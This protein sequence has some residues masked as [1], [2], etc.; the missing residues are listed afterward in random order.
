MPDPDHGLSGASN[1][2][3]HWNIR[4]K[5][6]ILLVVFGL[7][8]A[9]AVLSVL[10]IQSA[11]VKDGLM[12]KLGGAAVT[13]A[14]VV[15]L[16]LSERYGDA[17]AFAMNRAA[18]DAVNWGSPDA[19]NEL[20]LAMNGYVQLY[21]VYALTMIVAPDG[22]VLAVNSIDARCR[23]IDTRRLYAANFLGAPWIARPMKGEFLDGRNGLTGTYVHGPYREAAVVD[24]AGRDGL[25]LAFAA[26]IHDSSGTFLGVWIN[27]IDFAAIEELIAHT[28]RAIS[29]QG[30]DAA[31]I[32]LLDR[33][34]RVL[35]ERGGLADGVLARDRNLV[36][37]ELPPAIRSREANHGAIAY[38]A[39]KTGEPIA[40]G[41]AR[42]V[43][44]LDFP[45]LGWTVIVR[46]PAAEVFAIW[47]HVFNGL[48]LTLLA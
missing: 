37:E 41:F 12:V 22:R 6:V 27:L 17:Q 26:P 29:G 43:G 39:P 48:L 16:H 7:I 35:A 44:F 5:L 30:I 11:T 18:F 47:H 24:I 28:Q 36:A 25:T 8:P 46:A 20:V 15:D 40:A 1:R 33:E 2:P 45:G 32:T 14:Q 34:G 23:P 42:S 3:S 19:K 13:L 31:T 4:A 38:D 10:S 21:G 9:A